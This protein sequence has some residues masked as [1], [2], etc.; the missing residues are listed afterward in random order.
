MFLIG[1]LLSFVAM[2]LWSFA[3]PLY[4]APDEPAHVAK[5]AAVVRGQ[6]LG[7]FAGATQEAFGQVTIPD[8]YASSANRSIP[9]CYHHKPA[10]PASCAPKLVGG[11]TAEGA[12][13]YVARYPPLYYAIVGLPSLLGVGD[14]AI[15]LMRLMSALLCSVFIGLA[16]MVAFTWSRSRL[17]LAGVVVAATPMVLFIGGVVNPS[18][19]EISAAICTWTA[20]SVLVLEHLDDPPPGLV[21]VLGVSASVFELTR[22]LSPFWLALT[23]VAVVG[24]SDIRRLSGLFRHRS[25]RSALLAVVVLGVLA[26]AWI[27]GEHS[28]AV[29]S[30]VKLGPVPESKILEVSFAHNDFYLQDMVGVFGWFD[31]YSPTLTYVVWYGLVALL[32]ITAAVVARLRQAVVLGVLAVA[33]VVVPV[34]VSSSQAHK[35]GYTW[36]GRDTLPLAVGLP[37]LAGALVGQS[38]LV[39]H[40]RRLVAVIGLLAVLAQFGAFFEALRRYAVGTVGPDFS[41]LV[42]SSWRPPLGFAALL[43]L[44]AVVLVLGVVLASAAVGSAPVGGSDRLPGGVTLEAV[45]PIPMGEGRGADPSEEE[46]KVEAPPG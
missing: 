20:A 17:V 1:A 45:R 37:I 7:N 5:A 38:V 26:V 30:L 28:T 40:G 19:L 42:H 12:W 10:V 24:V 18:G 33:I 22:S 34:L 31:T 8:F 4:A 27:V 3:T 39:R 32:A 13:I 9:T 29:Y 46:P 21:A 11:T 14:W 6:L 44:E 35:Y 43:S 2:A 16:V 25:V 36:Q 15:Y 23:A 41:F